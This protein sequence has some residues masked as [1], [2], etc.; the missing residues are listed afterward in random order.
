MMLEKI[1]RK[2]KRENLI[3]DGDKIILGFS[4]GPDSVFLLQALLYAQKSID[5]QIVLAHINHLLRGKDSD[6]DENF[7]REVGEKLNLKTFIKRESIERVSK[8]NGIGLEEAG[9]EIRY[10][11]FNE[12]LE[13]ENGNKIGIAHNLDDQIETFLFRMFR[14]CS[15]DGL[16]GIISRDNIVRPI[17]EIYKKDIMDYL[18]SNM[19]EYR[20]DKTNFENEF[21]RNSI[22]LDLIPY[23]EEKYNSNFKDKIHNLIDEIREVN[24]ILKPELSEY[25]V[26]LDTIEKV[27]IS[28]VLKESKYIQMK[29]LN[30]YLA[31]NLIEVSRE[32]L[33]NVLKVMRSNGSK[34]INF[35][36]GLTLKKEYNYMWIQKEVIKNNELHK[37][38]KEVVIPFKIEFSNYVIETVESQESYGQNEF[39]T[40]LQKGDKITIRNRREGDRIKPLGMESYKKLK[41]IFINEKVPKEERDQVPLL[42]KNNEIVW[43]AGIKKSAVFQ[44]EKNKKGIK[45]IIRRQNEE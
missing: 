15:L 19:I 7:V 12:I 38:E 16:E 26:E 36:K 30:M 32:K 13:K 2:I 8:E 41:D 29:I 24:S 39:L 17:N 5:F 22:R 25:T 21:T 11:F 6:G 35:E 4:G 34:K 33:L 27:D 14:G 20:V 3:E 44:G 9:R 1:L 28:K 42:E 31:K 18:D 43:I 40:N 10:S 23:I 45:L 37:L